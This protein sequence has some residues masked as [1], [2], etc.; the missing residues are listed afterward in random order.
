MWRLL[1]TAA[2]VCLMSVAPACFAA[3]PTSP[4]KFSSLRAVIPSDMS[5]V[6]LLQ[7]R[8]GFIWIGTHNTGLYRY[9]GYQAVRYAHRPAD[10]RSL[11]N[12]QISALFEDGAGRLW[13][14]SQAG[15][16]RYNPTT[17]DFT[18]FAAPAGPKN[19]R[20]I[21][22][23]IGDGRGGMWLGTWG[24]LQHFDPAT[25]K[26]VQYVHRDGDADSLNSNDVNAIALDHRGGLWVATWPGG[27]DYLPAGSKKFVHFRVDDSA[28]PDPKLNLVRALF[29][30][31]EHR[32]WIGT[33]R[34]AYRWT[35][36]APWSSRAHLPSPSSR[37]SG[38]YQDRASAVWAGTTHGGLLR[39]NGAAEASEVFVHRPDDPYSVQSDDI[40]A[41]MQDRGGVMW[42][43]T[44]TAGI[45]TVNLNSH[46]FRRL[47]PNDANE[48]KLGVSN[49][50][51][52]IAGAP[53]NKIWLGSRRGFSLFDPTS[54]ATLLRYFYDPA[55]QGELAAKAVYSLYQQPGGPLW[56]ATSAGL[57]AFTEKTRQFQAYHFGTGAENFI[58][59]VVP[60]RNGI[61]WLGTG[62]N[63]VR[64][65]PATGTHRVFAHDDHNADSLSL[66]GITCI[67][68]DRL[69]RVWVGSE[70]SSG[71]DMLDPATGR[72]RHFT[73]DKNKKD[74]L[75]DDKITTIFE[76]R[77]G[78]IWLGTSV[79]L[80][81]IV[82]SSTGDIGFR[83]N[84][85]VGSNGPTKIISIAQDQGGALWLAT[86]S[87]LLA[88]DASTGAIKQYGAADGMTD[89]FTIGAAYAGADGMLYF[90]S[91]QGMTVVDPSRVGR[92]VHTPQVSITDIG[93][94]GRSLREAPR[95]PGV[96]LDGP[97]TAPSRLVLPPDASAFSIAFAA[98]DF[99]DSADNRYQYKLTGFDKDWTDA[100]AARRSASY[101]NLD[102]GH[103]LF[104][105]RAM[106]TAGLW[107]EHAA[108]LRITI[109][110]PFWKTGWFRLLSASMLVALFVVLYRLRIGTLK[111][112]QARLQQLV[113]ERTHALE[114]SNQKLAALSTTDGL[115]NI[116][117]RRGFDDALAA[118]WSRATRSG[119]PLA[120]AMIDVD[121]FKLYN[122]H[123]GH[124]AGDHC[125]IEVARTIA[126]H[127]RRAGDLAARYGG[128]EFVLLMPGC[129]GPDALATASALCARVFA[130][131]LPHALSNHGAVSVSIGVSCVVPSASSTPQDLIEAA[132]RALYKAKQAGRNCACLAP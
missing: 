24:G 27:I 114:E 113:M 35:D 11:P 10:A 22:R 78:R 39:W 88:L 111:R 126:A 118:A 99:T 3:A 71:L 120:L 74:G 57:Y 32:L 129:T 85:A 105:V 68:E 67:L 104:A 119:E 115:T 112:T 110:P 9:D 63:L 31:R 53:D 23:I 86:V 13:I 101:T 4:L 109:L 47:L 130:R 108:T 95:Q 44:F 28:S 81:E 97:V 66:T 29:F 51:S 69:G 49:A 103:Y 124:Q 127:G 62:R 56:L 55:G 89:G 102:P 8:Q 123:Y 25:G 116:T 2:L 41:V 94:G 75:G 7:D 121:F 72:V 65:D 48:A 125:L 106:N 60:G 1:W 77:E 52:T 19:N 61:L 128:E 100:D 122:D 91:L 26:F 30:D 59:K 42:V 70:W 45:N 43:G 33:E 40:R 90:G 16:A 80:S 50:L 107:S 6:A 79:G 14:G 37:I 20:L 34:G 93:V 132:D 98:L 64:F 5:T 73:Y 58:N 18:L 54:G 83:S 46:G 84:G 21:T 38:F 82:T 17:D 76:S 15:L 117:N 131:G 87:G 92:T 96:V 36:G 12:D